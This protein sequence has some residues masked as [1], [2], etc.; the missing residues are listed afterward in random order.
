MTDA[1]PAALESAAYPVTVRALALIWLAALAALGLRVAPQ[2]VHAHWPGGS[3][4]LIGAAALLV[5]CMGIAIARS[6]TRLDGDEL[7]QSWLWR[8]RVRAADATSVKLVDIPGLRLLVAPRLLVRRRGGGMT[9]FH[10]A[11][12]QLLI[13]FC[14]LVAQRQMAG[15]NS[16]AQQ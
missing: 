7:S 9:W 1:A 6:R 4:A 5:L 15:K 3:L 8:K 10:S 11:D 16:A 13:A 14:T 12:A 2:L